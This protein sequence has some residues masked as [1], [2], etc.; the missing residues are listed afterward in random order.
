MEQR[1]TLIGGGLAGPLLSIYLARSGFAV[2]VYERRADMRTGG[3]TEGRSI[4]LALSTRGIHALRQ[5]GLERDILSLAIPMK[6]RMMHA[7]DGTLTF[8]PYGKD[9]TEVIYSISRAQLNIAL[10]DA[11]ERTGKVRFHF[12]TRCTGMDFATGELHLRDEMAK[13][14]FSLRTKPV[15]GTDGSASVLRESM[16]REGLANYTEDY[17]EYGYKELSIP[18]AAGGRFAM[19]P[20]ALHIWP[21]KTFMLIALPNLD[22]S[23]T[24]ILFYPLK[25]EGSFETLDRPARIRDFF[26]AQ[27]P[28][29]LA[30]MPWLEKNFVVNPTGSMV[31]VRCFPWHVADTLLLLGDASHAIVPFFGQGMNCAFEDCTVFMEYF[32]RCGDDWESLFREFEQSRKPHCDAIAEMALENFVEMRDLVADPNFLF[33]KKVELELE[34]RFPTTF[35]PRYGMV[36]FHRVP[37]A[38]ALERG[39]I[40][41]R[42]L[43][44]VCDKVARIEDV[45]W[46]KAERLIRSELTPLG[47]YGSS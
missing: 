17:L 6:G 37:Y 44:L 46:D 14:Q 27:F 39:K 13:R 29:A 20:N 41:D 12:H 31:T 47:H 30:L 26:Q 22:G 15:I 2:D 25:G 34:K 10:M 11:A 1:I 23:F 24:A 9:E 8:Q 28:D 43:N 5:V 33:R 45:D 7:V 21:R 36:T 16:R 38:I 35:I 4:N 3:S 40:Q 18:P 32:G 19:E 42:I